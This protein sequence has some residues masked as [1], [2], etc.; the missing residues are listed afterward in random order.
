MVLDDLIKAN[1]RFVQAGG[2]GRVDRPRAEPDL[3][4]VAGA[5]PDLAGLIHPA[6]GL[7][8]GQ[9]VVIQ[10]G[11][12]WGGKEGQ[13]LL[14]SAVLGVHLHGCRQVVV[15]GASGAADCPPSRRELRRRASEAGI[16]PGSSEAERLLELANGPNSPSAG[17]EET[18]RLLRHSPLLPDDMPVHGC[19]LDPDTG[20]LQVIDRDSRGDAARREQVARQ[21]EP[22]YEQGAPD[23]PLPELPEIPL[24]EI[25][26]LD[27]DSLA[28][29]KP[30]PET[31]KASEYGQALSDGQKPG[32]VPFS[33]MVK[34][35]AP[36]FEGLDL[37]EPPRMSAPAISFEVPETAAIQDTG[38]G[39]LDMPGQPALLGKLEVEA[40]PGVQAVE[41]IRPVEPPKPR[42]HVQ[43]RVRVQP[44]QPEV[45]PLVRGRPMSAGQADTPSVRVDVRAG[46]Y[47][48]A[49]A[50]HAL[51][52]E[53]QRALLKVARFLG[54][55]LTN[56]DRNQ[57]LGRI[58][59]GA[60]SGQE[61]GELLKLLV[62]PVL[63][64]GKKRYAVINEL[65]KIKEDIPRLGRDVALALLE[66]TLKG[67]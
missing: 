40:R 61:T 27:I 23:I 58:R 59:R 5:G 42:P 49:G 47:S 67:L 51:D 43:P 11:G 53:L 64:L 39:E 55:E 36:V 52:P 9:A 12:A 18:V 60:I 48:R 37:I 66:Q 26:E 6:L 35:A 45:T 3:L 10:L 34:M 17:V 15:L 24:P 38:L 14:R 56:V 20:L 44:E 62:T 30:P 54:S 50:E 41:S 13:E 8:P 4:V 63:R 2:A 28:E 25:P 29:P 22:S 21:P 65:L 7:E 57:I 32:P 1:A 16:R 33:A 31:R 46:Y 19:L